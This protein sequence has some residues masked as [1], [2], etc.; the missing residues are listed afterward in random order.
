MLRRVAPCCAVW[1][2]RRRIHHGDTEGTEKRGGWGLPFWRVGLSCISGGV[3]VVGSVWQRLGG[4]GTLG[5]PT[6]GDGVDREGMPGAAREGMAPGGG[7]G[8]CRIGAHG[9]ST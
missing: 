8:G 4:G 9:V 1:R 6:G 2:G 3:V 7:R 5:M